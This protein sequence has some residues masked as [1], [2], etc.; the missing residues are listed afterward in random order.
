MISI[1]TFLKDEEEEIVF[2]NKHNSG[3]NK[4]RKEVG[5]LS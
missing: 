5:T 1:V 4:Q 3:R 2:V